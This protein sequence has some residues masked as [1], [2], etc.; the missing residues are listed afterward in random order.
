M[1]DFAFRC[2]EGLTV[3][4]SQTG[5]QES[6]QTYQS[7]VPLNGQFSPAVE[8]SHSPFVSAEGPSTL[9][10]K[11]SPSVEKLRRDPSAFCRSGV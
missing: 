4:Q 6:P 9:H 5:Y 7:L 10:S 3:D 1:A 11:S 8:G 2:A